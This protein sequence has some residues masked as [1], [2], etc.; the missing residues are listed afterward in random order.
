MHFC[1]L[2]KCECKDFIDQSGVGNCQGMS[3]MYRPI[4][5]NR[6]VCY[7]KDPDTS[8]CIDRQTCSL[9]IPERCSVSACEQTGI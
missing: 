7:L 4:E 5:D 1:I 9:L 2:D 3:S 6:A 8:A